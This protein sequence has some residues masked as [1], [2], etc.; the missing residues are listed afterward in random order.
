LKRFFDSSVLVPVFYA[1]HLHHELSAKAFLAASRADSFCALQ[2]LGEVYSTLTGLPVRP[3]ITGAE[4][5]AI[6]KQIR[7]R[8]TLVSLAEEEYVVALESV[9]QSIVGGAVYDALIAH[10]AMKAGVDILLTWNVRH[11][12][13]FGPDIAEDTEI[14]FPLSR[15]VLLIGSWES[16]KSE[17]I[18]LTRK[19]ITLYYGMTAGHCQ[20]FL[21]F[22][23]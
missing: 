11:F 5:V 10:C 12:T 13:R 7:N 14:S 9:S 16:G 19:N 3:R 23:D 21:F 2:T 8:L 22:I 4:G 20:R 18:P 17:T 15:N 1:D 6:L